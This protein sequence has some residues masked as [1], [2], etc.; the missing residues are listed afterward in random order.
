MVQV[1]SLSLDMN[2][3]FARK[4]SLLNTI[5]ERTDSQ[6]VNNHDI[7]S[8]MGS[9]SLQ[10]VIK[11]TANLSKHHIAGIINMSDNSFHGAQ[12]VL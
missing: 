8:F 7:L 11:I 9:R 10:H 3:G 12:I 6:K 5:V 4:S 2:W 1:E